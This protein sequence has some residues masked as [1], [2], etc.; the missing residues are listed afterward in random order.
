MLICVIFHFSRFLTYN[1][2]LVYV[3]FFFLNSFLMFPHSFPEFHI[4]GS[5]EFAIDL[6]QKEQLHENASM[7]QSPHFPVSY[8]LHLE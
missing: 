4:G 3:G 2:Y 6:Q 7:V 1:F 8:G 5:A